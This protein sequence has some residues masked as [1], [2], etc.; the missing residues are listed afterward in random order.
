MADGVWL[1]SNL[2]GCKLRVRRLLHKFRGSVVSTRFSGFLKIR[3]FE[4]RF[5]KTGA[6]A[7][8]RM[9]IGGSVVVIDAIVWLLP[10][11]FREA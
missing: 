8:L 4:V 2:V 1:P 3:G 7:D 10:N 5:W 11:H 9:R 6:A